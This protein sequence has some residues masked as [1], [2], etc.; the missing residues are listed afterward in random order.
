M[1]TAFTDEQ[2]I[3]SIQASTESREQVFEY[4]YLNTELKNKAFSKIN[5]MIQEPTAAEDI[6]LDSLLAFIKNVRYNKFEGK[7][8]V[9]TYIVSICGFQCLRYLDR[10]KKEKGKAEQYNTELAKEMEREYEEEP[11]FLLL[12]DK[13]YEAR[14]T[15]KVYR[16]LS[17]GC[18]RAFRQK[19][20]QAL[21]V[22]EMAER[23]GV[24]VQSVKNS[25][26]RCYKKLRALIEN[27]AE[28]MEL[29]KSQY[30]KL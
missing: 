16:Q 11:E 27:D 5:K 4:L 6:F 24:E 21:S 15:R 3:E 2:I 26:S 29:I 30:G 18:R 22:K 12:D 9:F 17:E 25:L 23:F 19:Y 8:K 13:R 28:I 7:S 20:G 1:K 14:L 10:Q